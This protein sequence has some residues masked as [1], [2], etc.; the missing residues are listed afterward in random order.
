[1]FPRKRVRKYNAGDGTR[2]DAVRQVA[3]IGFKRERHIKTR[4]E[5]VRAVAAVNC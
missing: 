5:I 1:M 4:A 3:E 2:G